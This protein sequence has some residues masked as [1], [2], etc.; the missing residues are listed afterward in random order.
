LLLEPS[1][2]NLLA[3]S[4]ELPHCSPASRM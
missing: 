1:S 4:D 2:N 3:L